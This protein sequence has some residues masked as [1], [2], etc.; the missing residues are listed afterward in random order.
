MKAQV[1]PSLNKKMGLL[2][3]SAEEQVKDKLIDIA[4]FATSRSPSDTGS[5]VT[6]FSFKNSYSSGRGRSSKGKPR[7]VD[8][9]SEGLSQLVADIQKLDLKSSTFVL[10]NGAPHAN[11]V[12]K[13][14][15]HP[16]GKVTPGYAVFAQVKDKFR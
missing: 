4:Q 2:W 9:R 7:G 3:Q 6:S 5:Y 15:V 10:S 1:N 8:R 13:G 14:W 16:S 12:E 11:S